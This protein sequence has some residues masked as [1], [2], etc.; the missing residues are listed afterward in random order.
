MGSRD[1][2]KEGANTQMGGQVPRVEK[3]P[4]GTVLVICVLDEE[5]AAFLPASIVS[6]QFAAGRIL[7]LRGAEHRSGR[8]KFWAEEAAPHQ[9]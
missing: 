3:Q 4:E 2:Y 1:D 5:I 6:A 7:V 9:R 8:L